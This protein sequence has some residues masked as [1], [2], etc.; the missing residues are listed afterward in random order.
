LEN[1]VKFQVPTWNQIYAMLRNQ[2]EKIRHCDFKPDVIVGVTREMGSHKNLVR[3]SRDPQA[4]H[5]AN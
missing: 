3:P 5:D 2:T 4:C 1:E